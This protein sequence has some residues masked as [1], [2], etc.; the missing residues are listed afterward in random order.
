MGNLNIQFTEGFYASKQLNSKFNEARLRFALHKS[1]VKDLEKHELWGNEIEA[2]MNLGEYDQALKLANSVLLK[3]DRLKLL[4]ILA[5]QRKIKDCNEDTD[6]SDQIKNL[7]EQIDFSRI[8]EKGFE[9][10]AI[11]IYTNTNLAIELVEKVTDNS[12]NGNSLDEALAYL[13]LYVNEVNKKSKS[14]IADV[15]TINTKIKNNDLKNIT[16]AFDFMSNKFNANEIISHVNSLTKFSQKIFLL[17]NWIKGNKENQEIA[18]VIEYTL[19]EIVK[20]SDNNVP[21]ATTLSEIAIPLP[22]INNTTIVEKLITL[23]DTHKN[24]IDRPTKDYVK[25]QLKI[26]EAL[27]NHSTRQSI[28]IHQIFYL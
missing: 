9:I 24:I 12:A 10:A 2:R 14:P 21:S 13:M 7:Y 19:E 6:L 18:K 15:E 16:Q 25:L 28:N 5:K 8:R 17:K 23:F 1:S 4:A 3:E 22:L 20:S 27:I 26:A 11:L